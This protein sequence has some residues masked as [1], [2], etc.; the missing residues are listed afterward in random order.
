MAWGACRP[1]AGDAGLC[2]PASFISSSL[3]WVVDLGVHLG[4][5]VVKKQGDPHVEFYIFSSGSCFKLNW[6]SWTLGLGLFCRRP[7]HLP[8]FQGTLLFSG[9]ERLVPVIEQNQK[10][11]DK[12]G[13]RQ[14]L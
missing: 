7:R 11:P 3:L 8:C 10:V 9:G 2:V 5:C 4:I 12:P 13:R 1:E 6:L 14:E